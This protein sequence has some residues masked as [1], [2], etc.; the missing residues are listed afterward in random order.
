MTLA[1]AATEQRFNKLM[2]YGGVLLVVAVFLYL[3]WTG[4]K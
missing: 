4:A 3:I 2:S 1:V